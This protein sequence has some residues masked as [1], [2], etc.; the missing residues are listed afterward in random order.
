MFCKKCGAEIASGNDFCYNCGERTDNTVSNDGIKPRKEYKTWIFILLSWCLGGIGFGFGEFYAGYIKLGI[1]RII[2]SVLGLTLIVL[3]GS[4]K[5]LMALGLALFVLSSVVG[6]WETFQVIF[7]H[8]YMLENGE[9]VM[10]R[11]LDKILDRKGVEKA[12]RMEY[13]CSVKSWKV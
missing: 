3:S 7:P 12:L 8:A 9:I 11:N 5:A 2:A 13:G 6:Y 10:I 1:A 4:V